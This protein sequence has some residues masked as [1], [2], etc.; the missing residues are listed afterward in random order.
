MV[1]RSL[2]EVGEMTKYQAAITW[3]AKNDDTE[4]LEDDKPIISVTASLVADLFNRSHEQVIKDLRKE[5]RGVY[6]AECKE[7]A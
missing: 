1:G 7:P 4:W 5:L 3:I 2:L 6:G